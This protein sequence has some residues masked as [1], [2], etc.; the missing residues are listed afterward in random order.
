[1]SKFEVSDAMVEAAI[2]AKAL[3][4][5]EPPAQIGEGEAMRAAII[6]A[7][8]ASGLVGRIAELE[9]KNLG[10]TRTMQEVRLVA[11]DAQLRAT[12]HKTALEIISDSLRI[13]LNKE[14]TV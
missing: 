5:F 9:A 6:A 14:P 2:A 10:L 4:W 11:V 12:Y 13:A 3:Y 7:I 8:E 1:M